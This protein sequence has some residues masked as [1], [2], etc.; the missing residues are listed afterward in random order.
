MA[1]FQLGQRVR[2]TEHI[3]R[4]Y[5]AEHDRVDVLRGPNKQWTSQAY[6]GK[7]LEGGEG[8]IVGKRTLS[9]GHYDY[10]WGEEPGVY[11]P[12]RHF[13]AYLIAFD[14][15]RKPVYVLPE[16][17]TPEADHDGGR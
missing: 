8:V 11:S 6:P 13:T 4:K 12:T 1:E 17:I 9:D 3:Q 2:Y 14:L 5:I 7:R 10:G 16:H 15:R